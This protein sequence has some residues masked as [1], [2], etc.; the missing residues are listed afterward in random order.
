MGGDGGG[1]GY[2]GDSGG[3]QSDIEKV[4]EELD[5]SSFRRVRRGQE[6]LDEDESDDN[7]FFVFLKVSI[8]LIVA[9]AILI[10][11]L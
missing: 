3:D 4:I 9:L 7:G 1:E 2:S 5:V 8:F 10:I 6:S 11:F